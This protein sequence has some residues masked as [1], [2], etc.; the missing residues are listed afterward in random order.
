[1]LAREPGHGEA[2]ALK[3][4]LEAEL[5]ARGRAPKPEPAPPS[6]EAPS[7][8]EPAAEP[9]AVVHA[10]ASH[11]GAAASDA[12][13]AALDPLDD[14]DL[15]ERYDVDEVVAIAVD[16]R[17]LYVYWEVR[18]TTLARARAA[19]ADGSLALRLGSVSAS[20][21]GPVNETHDVR[22]DEL[23]GDRY[24]RDVTPGAHLRVS[25]GWL[26]GDVFE[27]FAVGMEVTA[28]RV[29]P[30]ENVAH[31][32]GAWSPS[33]VA[34][35]TRALPE[36]LALSEARGGAAPA[37]PLRVSDARAARRSRPGATAPETTLR[38]ESTHAGEGGYM[39]VTVEEVRTRVARAAAAHRRE[40]ARPRG[41]AR[42]SKSAP[43]EISVPRRFGGASEL[44]RRS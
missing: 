3:A 16:P 10:D 5:A 43:A 18:P 20:W 38:R 30:A 11:A 24:L 35:F 28:P 42:S 39:H 32:F 44:T 33:P 6:D 15:P 25:I 26:A 14:E 13:D 21:S 23:H 36:L 8:S 1:M 29:L 7:S 2:T 12:A 31:A 9:A 27:P 40:R 34:P 41:P 19:H 17:T 4:R 37:R 22:V